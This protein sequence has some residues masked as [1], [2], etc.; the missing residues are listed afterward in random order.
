MATFTR[1]DLTLAAV[2]VVRIL[3]IDPGTQV[4]GYGCL[5]VSL[6]GVR[7]PSGEVPLALRASN[8]VLSGGSTRDVRMVAMGVMRLGGRSADLSSRLLSL[9]D[10]FRGLLTELKPDEVALEEA[11]YGKSVQ[12]ALRIGEARGVVLAESARV[13]APV[14]QFAPAR[15]KR[16]V[17]GRGAAK[18]ETVAAM[19]EQLLR[20]G[21]IGGEG[22]PHDA[23]DALA[24]AWT[25]LEQRRS[26]LLHV[27]EGL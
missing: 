17:T 10:Q 26:P 1:R 9:A 19:V 25:R 27:A 23:T 22:V 14:H 16:V 7:R 5:E 24:V 20:V 6:A 2:A 11:F 8:T 12:A 18:K 15:I 3:G 21:T 13:G 4:V